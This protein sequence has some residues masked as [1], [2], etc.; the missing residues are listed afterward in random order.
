MIRVRFAPSPTGFLHLG[1]LRTALYDFL[2]AKKNKGQFILRIE[3]TDS[4][5]KVSG[6]IENLIR[7]LK[8]VGLDYDEGPFFDEKNPEKIIEKGDYGPYIQSKRLE[9]YQSMVKKLIDSDKAYY[10]F[11]SKEDLEQSRENQINQGKAATYDRRCR[12]LTREEVKARLEAQQ[13]HVVRLK[14]PESGKIKFEDLIRGQVEFDL[15]L[16]DDQ[17]LLKS[18][19]YPTYHLAVVVDDYLMKIT[20]IIRGEEW[21]PSVPKHILIYQAFGWDLPKFAHLSLLFNPDK[22]KLSKRQGDVAVEDYLTAGYLPE[23]L[24]NFIALLGWSVGDDREIFSLDELIKE[25]SIEKVQKAGAIFNREKLDWMNGLYIRKMSIKELTK[26]C[27]HYL[28]KADLIEEISVTSFKIKE[29]QVMVDPEWLEKVVKLE[30]ERMKKLSEIVEAVKFFFVKE[31]DYQGEIL[32]WKKSD[33]KKTKGNLSIIREKLMSIKNFKAVEIQKELEILG[34][35][36]GTGDI[37]WP[38]RVALSGRQSSPPPAEMAEILGRDQSLK[39][40]DQAMLKL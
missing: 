17:V 28:I 29:S 34:K 26:R 16:I 24:I 14:V 27:L 8:Q 33:N 36:Y 19:G 18:D 23:A 39:R 40:I 2:L 11:C 6:A 25:F 38:L 32:I 12:Q 31:L 20:H 1:S 22:S 10:C 13:P 21:L 7:T 9:I 5:R 30:Q 3:D 15:K 35:Q 37:F 4:Q